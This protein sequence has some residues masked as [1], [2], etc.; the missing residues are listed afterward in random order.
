MAVRVKIERKP[1][2]GGVLIQSGWDGPRWSGHIVVLRCARA[3]GARPAGCVVRSTS[4]GDWSSGVKLGEGIDG[5]RFLKR[6]EKECLEISNS[7]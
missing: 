2:D 7:S 5:G 4:Y 1:G 6:M 3:D